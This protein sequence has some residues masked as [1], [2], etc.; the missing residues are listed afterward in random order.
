METRKEGH[1]WEEGDDSVVQ[2]NKGKVILQM[3][4][5]NSSISEESV[6]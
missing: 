5:A 1:A 4:K 2:I 3:L 6:E